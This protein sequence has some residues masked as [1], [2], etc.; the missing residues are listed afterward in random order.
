MYS[1]VLHCTVL[2]MYV[3]PWPCPAVAEAGWPTAGDP[4]ASVRNAADWNQR[5]LGK[6]CSGQGTPR[7][8]GLRMRTWLFEAFDE[9]WKHASDTPWEAH[10]G[11]WD[12]EGRAKY[13]LSPR[14]R[15]QR[16][17]YAPCLP[18]A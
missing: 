17:R 15:T 5:L 16:H 14:R 10:W 13:P 18:S 11:I 4:V 8:P 12:W 6:V 1:T 7:R 2:A 3:A 9:P